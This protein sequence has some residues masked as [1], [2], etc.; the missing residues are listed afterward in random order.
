[1]FPIGTTLV[2]CTATD[3]SRNSTSAT[4]NVTVTDPHT[5]GAMSGAGSAGAGAN[6]VIF[7]FDVKESGSESGYL[8]ATIRQDG[9]PRLLI[10]L[11]VDSIFFTN[12][13]SFTPGPQPAS[14]VDSVVFSGPA[15]FNGSAG[16]TY[17][18]RATDRGEPGRNDTFTLIVRNAA[19]VVVANVGGTLATGNIDSRRV[20]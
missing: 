3:S 2:T 12:D 11:R 16:H 9:L 20:P 4:F 15:L 17:E 14:G 6:S 1:M 19:G 7:T 10:S 18:A 13:A 8:V 5:A